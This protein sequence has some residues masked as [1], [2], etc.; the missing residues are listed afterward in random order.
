MLLLVVN[1]SNVMTYVTFMIFDL[2]TYRERRIRL[3]RASAWHFVCILSLA[4]QRVIQ[5]EEPLL[6]G[7]TTRTAGQAPPRRGVAFRRL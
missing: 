5:L 2:L 1:M 3:Y 7:S 6:H 4:L